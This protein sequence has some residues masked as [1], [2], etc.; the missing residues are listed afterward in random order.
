M[1]F[2]LDCEFNGHNGCIISICLYSDLAY[3]YQPII[4]PEGTV[5]EPWVA[6]NVLPIIAKEPVELAKAQIML[7]NF[8]SKW[9]ENEVN[10]S[11]LCDSLADVPYLYQMLNP[12]GYPELFNDFAN[13]TITV[14]RDVDYRSQVPHNAYYDAK[15]L[16]HAAMADNLFP[17][18]SPLKK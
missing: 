17:D 2:A 4:I 3:F 8:L 18:L 10:L 5:I 7:A 12:G 15:A 1:H 11:V 13:F 6:E 16:Y 9:T 14:V